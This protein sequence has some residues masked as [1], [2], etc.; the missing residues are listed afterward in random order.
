MSSKTVPLL[1]VVI[2]AW[3]SHATIA[4]CLK[5]LAGQSFQD[6]ETIVVDSSP[7]EET[8][9]I[10]TEG[11]PQVRFEHSRQRLLPHAARNRG[12]ELAQGRLLV[13][14][15]PDCYARPDWLERLLE[16]YRRTR[17]TVV[18][19]LAC[20]GPGW[21]EQGLHLCKFSKWLP[22]GDLRPVDMSPTANMLIS[23][24]DFLEAGG[25]PGEQM[26]GDVVLSWTLQDGGRRLWLSPDAVVAHH[27]T[28]SF[29]EFLTER[30]VRGKMYGHLRSPR[31]RKRRGA[32]TVYL[33]ATILPVR[34]TRILGL[35][36]GHAVRARQG[37][38]FLATL[39]IVAA[40]HA[41]ALAGE[42]AAY[43]RPAPER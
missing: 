36:A 32:F 31:L 7:G 34:L 10:V 9:R 37:G 11:F 5:A 33:L 41:A 27:H 40:G 19:A 6:F 2:P 15:D 25:F 3:Q 17:G 39:P 28:Q 43:L 30:L 29:R 13:F 12:A 21:R 8:E 24:D 4:G 23:R 20:H 22:A 38:L 26:L 18:G 42:A 35:V 16:A 14:T 1:S